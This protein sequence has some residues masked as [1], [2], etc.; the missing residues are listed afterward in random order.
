MVISLFRRLLLDP[1]RAI[2]RESARERSDYSGFDWSPL[3]I[4]TTMAICLTLQEYF[5]HHRQFSS[6]FPW[7]R[8]DEYYQLKSFAWW[9][10]WRVGTYVVIPVLVILAMPGH[11]V[12]DY[13]IRFE[14]FPKHLWIYIVLFLLILPAVVISSRFP[15][16]LQTY[17]FYAW[18]NR[19]TFD[20]WAWQGMYAL[21]FASLE[22]FFRGFVL[23]GL[24]RAL[25]SSAIFVMAVPYCMIHFGGK[26]LPETIGAIFAGIILGTLAMRTRSIWGGVLIHVGVALT[27][28]ILALSHCPSAE[29]GRP[30]R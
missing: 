21:Q 5:G 12:R 1:W 17:P 6:L 18:A 20:F 2:D 24:R 8:G 27:M 14:N 26:P 10:A 15:S 16:F 30:C 3:V 28:D 7:D 9:T 19:S 11:R 29:T 25:G 4:L 22:F 13:Y 23:H